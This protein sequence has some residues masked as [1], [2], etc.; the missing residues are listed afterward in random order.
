[1]RDRINWISIPKRSAA[2]S[3]RFLTVWRLSV[4][5]SRTS[6]PSPTSKGFNC[7]MYGCNANSRCDCPPPFCFEVKISSTFSFP[8]LVN[9]GIREPPLACFR[10]ISILSLLSI[11]L[12]LLSITK[13][14]FIKRTLSQSNKYHRKTPTQA[15][16]ANKKRTRK[17]YANRIKHPIRRSLLHAKLLCAICARRPPSSNKR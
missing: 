5:A 3:N 1:M 12:S 17:P 4:F 16:L 8:S 13:H 6:S 9:V 7:S 10:R 2:R 11:K 14:Y 15:V